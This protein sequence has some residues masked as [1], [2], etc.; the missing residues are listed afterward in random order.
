MD[1]PQ[2][3]E[4]SINRLVPNLSGLPASVGELMNKLYDIFKIAQPFN[5]VFQVKD[6]ARAAYVKYMKLNEKSI[7][8]FALKKR[9]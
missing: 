1:Y 2:F 7:M 3:V 5:K 6:T 8:K 9:L 4:S